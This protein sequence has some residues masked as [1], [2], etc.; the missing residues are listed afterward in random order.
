MYENIFEPAQKCTKP[1]FPPTMTKSDVEKR[2]QHTNARETCPFKNW[3]GRGCV[4][5][6]C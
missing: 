4:D 3:G 2:Q 1:V 6:N 5:S